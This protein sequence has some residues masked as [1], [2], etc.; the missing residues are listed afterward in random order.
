M[1]EVV[2]VEVIKL[3]DTGII[4]PISDTAW[5]SLVQ[6]VPKKGRMTVIT[7]EKNRL[8]PTR[9]TKGW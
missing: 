9:T 3:L 8:I 5:V 1:K 4:Y 2:K 7:N 6:L